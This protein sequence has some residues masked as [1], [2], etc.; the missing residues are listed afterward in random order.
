VFSSEG[1]SFEK[2]LLSLSPDE[3]EAVSR[4]L[5][6]KPM[7][8]PYNCNKLKRALLEPFVFDETGVGDLVTVLKS[9]QFE[10]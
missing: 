1:C 9:I 2:V 5:I 4:A 7:V 8:Y 10:D 6:D 3:P